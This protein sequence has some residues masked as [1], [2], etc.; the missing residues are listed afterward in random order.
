M[1]QNYEHLLRLKFKLRTFEAQSMFDKNQ[2]LVIFLRLPRLV[3][4]LSWVNTKL[5]VKI[6]V[7]KASSRYILSN[8][9]STM[10]S[11]MVAQSLISGSAFVL[12]T[13]KEPE[14]YLADIFVAVFS[15]FL[16]PTF[17]LGNILLGNLVIHFENPR[18]CCNHV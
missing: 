17:G 9:S 1:D 18:Y 3:S 16:V 6:L 8:R 4:L 7:I 2:T 13:I 11:S 15:F 10:S 14:Y 12:V 5:P